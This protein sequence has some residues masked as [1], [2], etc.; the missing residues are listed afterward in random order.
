MQ[1]P[2]GT[3]IALVDGE[4]FELFR[5]AGNEADP[6]LSSIASPTLDV[7]NKGGGTRHHSSAA[8]PTGNLLEEDAH[9]AAVVAWLDH[10]VLGHRIEHLAVIAAPRTLGEM[11]RHYSKQLEA[12]LVLEVPKDLTGRSGQEIIAALRGK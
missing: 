6:S 8:N 1:L 4:K 11:R 3:F 10:E 5:N 9:A 12:T 2:H 7:H